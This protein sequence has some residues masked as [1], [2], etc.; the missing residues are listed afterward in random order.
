METQ[1]MDAHVFLTIE[2]LSFKPDSIFLK[3]I[4]ITIW[5]CMKYQFKRHELHIHPRTEYGQD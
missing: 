1:E 4:S 2:V 3:I 5:K